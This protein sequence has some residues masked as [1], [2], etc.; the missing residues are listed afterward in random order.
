MR[1]QQRVQRIGAV[2][3]GEADVPD[4]AALLGIQR[5]V[6]HAVRVELGRAL[7]A[8]IVQQV[9]VHV[10]QPHALKRRGQVA[11]RLFGAG[12]GP[13]QALRGHRVRVARVALHQRLFQRLLGRALVVDE[14]GVEVRAATFDERVHHL[15]KLLQVDALLVG[16]IKQR[17]AHAA[18]AQ[19]RRVFEFRSQ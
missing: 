1:R 14:R 7:A 6:P 13:G 12:R 18:E 5:E 2:V 16:G 19:L 17:Q 9:E 10:V 8:H 11:F 3:H 4:E 15:L